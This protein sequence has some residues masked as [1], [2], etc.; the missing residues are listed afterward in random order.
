[1]LPGA[2]DTCASANL[3]EDTMCGFMGLFSYY[4]S[5]P[6]F[7]GTVQDNAISDLQNNVFADNTYIGP[8]GFDGYNQ[9]NVNTW[10]Q[11]TGGYVYSGPGGTP[12]DP[13]DAG[14]TYTG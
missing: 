12:F 14:S 3:N 8:I 13:Q 9:P 7:I 6:P 5:T 4:G 11:W 1:V 10:A 2:V